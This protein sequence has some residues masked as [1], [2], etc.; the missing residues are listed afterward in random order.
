VHA[1]PD[2]RDGGLDLGGALDLEGGGASDPGSGSTTD[3]VRDEALLTELRT[4]LTAVQPVLPSRL[5]YDRKGSELFEAITTTE[6][7]YP[8]RTEEA[9]LEEVI[10]GWIEALRP[11]TLVELGAGAARK[12][13]TILDAMLAVGSGEVFCPVDVS[14]DFLRD[15]AVRLRLDY[16]RLRVMP[17]VADFTRAFDFSGPHP[18]P[19]LVAL[20]GSTIGNFPDPLA[21]DLLGGIRSVMGGEDAFLM[22]V[23][24]RPGPWKSVE[25]LELAYDD[26]EGLTREFNLNMLAVVRGLTGWDLDPLDYDHH[27]PW[28][29]EEGRI[30]MRLIARRPVEVDLGEG[31][32]LRLEEGEWIRTEVSCKYDQARVDRLLAGAGLQ[33]D[34]W[35]TDA[36]GRFGL[37]L[38]SP[39]R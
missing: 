32:F 14:A 11:R 31:A 20:L 19:S 24:L 5:F 27:A 1:T 4:G 28:V 8:T 2:R 10:P 35:V 13:R 25:R 34:E 23:D 15:V 22:G 6:A 12:T 18:D 9:L 36:R 16:P 3:P 39:S 26:P 30:E 17:E 21:I 37:V 7:Y 38:A 29:E 33:L